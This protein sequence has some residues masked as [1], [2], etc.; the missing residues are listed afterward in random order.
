[1]RKAIWRV[2]VRKVVEDWV[3]V[4]AGS[5]LEADAE[6]AKVPGVV[7]VVLGLTIPGDK[8]AG[9]VTEPLGVK[10]EL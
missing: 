2:R 4:T 5:A 9:P 8:L 7:G 6:A 1:M 3:E 10:E